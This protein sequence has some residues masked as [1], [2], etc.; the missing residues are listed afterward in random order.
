MS[1]VPK[2]RGRPRGSSPT[3]KEDHEALERAFEL[4]QKEG[5]P[6]T[7]ACRNAAN[8]LKLRGSNPEDRLRKRYPRFRDEKLAALARAKEARPSEPPHL[9]EAKA[10]Y[11]RMIAGYPPQMPS[12]RELKEIK[13][14]LEFFEKNRK[15]ISEA[16]AAAL[17][18]FK[19]LRR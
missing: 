16:Q 3:A 17:A 2:R 12:P 7:T 4:E 6:Y 1:E 11:A 10:Q 14:N 8:G 9:V 18:Y 13:R 15:T 5:M 19:S